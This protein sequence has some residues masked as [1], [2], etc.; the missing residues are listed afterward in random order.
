MEFPRWFWVILGMIAGVQ[1]THALDDGIPLV[2]RQP[3]RGAVLTRA[4]DSSQRPR[5]QESE[6]LRRKID[7]LLRT[8]LTRHWYPGAVDRRRGGFHQTL[9]RDWSLRPDENV[10]LVYQ[11]RMTWT[12]ATFAQYSQPDHDEEAIHRDG[13][14]ILS[15]EQDAPIARR[16]DRVGVYYGFKTMITGDASLGTP[17]IESTAC[18]TLLE[19]HGQY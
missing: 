4:V 18:L 15:W 17:R 10:F 9:A 16:L 5:D 3:G 13:T 2:G 19:S 6:L 14:P 11:A 8:E 7:E 12:A 1:T